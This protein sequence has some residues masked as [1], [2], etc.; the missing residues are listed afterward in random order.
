M[1][2]PSLLADLEDEV[3]ELDQE[4]SEHMSEEEIVK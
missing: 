2:N 1:I 4:I 3:D